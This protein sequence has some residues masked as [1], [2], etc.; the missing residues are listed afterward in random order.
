MLVTNDRKTSAAKVITR[1][2]RRMLIE[3]ALSD[4]VRF[5]HMNALSSTV[6]IKVDFDV[7]RDPMVLHFPFSIQS[8]DGRTRCGHAASVDQLRITSDTHQT[9]PGLLADEWSDSGF[10]EVPRQRIASRARHFIDDH[11]L[12]PEN[13][14]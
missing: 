2:A 9:T 11:Y 3:N 10:P 8:I 5:F 7:R 14:L 12:G 4:A 6:G 13:R 1:Y